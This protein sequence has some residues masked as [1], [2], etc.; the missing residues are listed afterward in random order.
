MVVKSTGGGHGGN[1]YAASRNLQRPIKTILDFS[2]SINPL[3]PSPKVKGTLAEGIRLIR[4]Y[5]DPD[6]QSLQSLLS[7]QWKL[8]PDHFVI[9]N[10]STEL[11]HL[12]PRALALR[13]ALIVGP[14]FSE[15]AE[16]L[17][18]AGTRT[19]TVSA[20]RSE[21]Y[22]PPLRKA[23]NLLRSRRAAFPFDAVVL[24]N[25][26]SPTG[27]ICDRAELLA[28]IGSAERSKIW[29]ILDET[30]VEYCR[31]QSMKPGLRRYRNL[32]LVRSFTKF[33]ALPGLRVGYTVS[34]PRVA[35]SLRRYQPPWSVNILAQIAAEAALQDRHHATLSAAYVQRERRRLTNL[36]R[37][38]PGLTVF[39]SQANFLLLELP[40]SPRGCIAPQALYQQ[41]LLVRDCASL[42]GLNART[43]RLAVRTENE[44]NRLVA[45]LKKILG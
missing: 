8:S 34:S 11:I 3:G 4:H 27:Q 23:R 38:L 13:S 44:N 28:L 15:Y 6:C 10:G 36:L 21:G 26:N 30:F 32:I 33:Y 29:V 43:I 12:L 25:P 9:G 5:P 24:C 40:D 20:L 45:A 31:R 1:V 16:A 18:R 7:S 22:R 2:A 42:P 39:P 14:T 35:A 41:G 17:T 37:S 19:Q